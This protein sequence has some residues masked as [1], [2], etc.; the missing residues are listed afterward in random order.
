MLPGR[1]GAAV[2]TIDDALL[3]DGC[4]ERSRVHAAFGEHPNVT[5]AAVPERAGSPVP[6]LI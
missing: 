1:V 2:W 3:A 5:E 4:A 6:E